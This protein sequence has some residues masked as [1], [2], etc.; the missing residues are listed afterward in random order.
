MVIVLNEYEW[1]EKMLNSHD[2]GK[3]PMET[4]ARISKYYYANHY[5]KREIRKKLNAFLLQC[6]PNISLLQWSNVIDRVIKSVNKYPLIELDGVSITK[7]ELEVIE[8][9]EGRQLKR[10]AFTLLCVAKYWDE[11]SP[12]NRHW[13][14]TSDKDIIQMA[15]INTS[16]KRQSMLFGQL[17][18]AGLIQFSKKIDNLNVR[19]MFIK[20][21][22]PA[23]YI[24]DFRNLG[25][26]YLKY[27]GEPYF[28]CEN[29]GIVTRIQD[30]AKGRKQK[31]CPSCALE[32]QTKQIVNATMKRRTLAKKELNACS[33]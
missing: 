31:Y 11:V 9:L 23:M 13:V 24:Q 18:N 21:G 4:L 6:D 8:T 12:K 25:Y 29:C 10:L 27:Y 22:E 14:N 32:V 7:D 26:Q 33:N 16:I 2:L 1:A 15:N 30:P 20:E 3:K 19:V 28:E 17:H 5:T